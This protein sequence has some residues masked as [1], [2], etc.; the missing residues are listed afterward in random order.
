MSLSTT[1]NGLN[2]EMFFFKE[3]G[4]P[5]LFTLLSRH[6]SPTS[7][8]YPPNGPPPSG[9]GPGRSPLNVPLTHCPSDDVRYGTTESIERLRNLITKPNPYSFLSSYH[10]SLDKMK[11]FFLKNFYENFFCF[12]TEHSVNTE[13]P[14]QPSISLQ[15][16]FCPFTT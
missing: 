9:T 2:L 11:K 10:Y 1:L 15:Y 12:I 5:L 6:P 4:V 13:Q 16:I 8:P 14:R 3:V 7:F